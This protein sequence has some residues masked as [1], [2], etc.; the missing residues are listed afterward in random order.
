MRKVLLTLF[1]AILVIGALAGAGFAGYRIGFN[2]GAQVSANGDT[3]LPTRPDRF[4][5][6]DMPFHNFGREFER[7]FN[8]GFPQGR[9]RMIHHGGFGLFGP[10]MFLEHIAFWGLII[11]LVYWLFTRSGWRL[12]RMQQTVQ[13]TPP[14]VETESKLQEQEPKNE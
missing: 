11:L 9:F 13:S 5:P 3:P 2:Q 14:N 1:A 7:G 4:G 6:R 8:H 10:F 12:T